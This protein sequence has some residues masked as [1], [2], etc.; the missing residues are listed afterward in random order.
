MDNTN[1]SIDTLIKLYN[2]YIYEIYS[3]I[4]K[5]NKDFNDNNNIWQIFEYYSAIQ[6]SKQ[7]NQIFVVYDDIHS[8]FK[9]NNDLSQNDTGIDICN[10][11][12]TIVQ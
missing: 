10:M 6:L 8:N 9:E 5:L 12:D 1:T 11:I 7:Y 4:I 2:I 3:N